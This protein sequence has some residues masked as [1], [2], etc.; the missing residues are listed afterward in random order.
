MTFQR[1][2]LTRSWR[3]RKQSSFQSFV[4]SLAPS[5]QPSPPF[6]IFHR[7]LYSLP[8]PCELPGPVEQRWPS[9]VSASE[10]W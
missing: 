3:E 8:F 5:L 1:A 7:G 6:L 2:R 10:H 9:S 4:P